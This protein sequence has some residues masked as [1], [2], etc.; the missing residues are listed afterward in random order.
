[1]FYYSYYLFIKIPG[2]KYKNKK[3]VETWKHVFILSKKF[4]VNKKNCYLMYISLWEKKFFDCLY[5]F[6]IYKVRKK[7]KSRK[8]RKNTN[9]LNFF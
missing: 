8:I 5:V 7:K 4:L 2:K 3:Y 6:Y 1:M 9:L